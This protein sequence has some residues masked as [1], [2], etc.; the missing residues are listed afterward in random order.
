[1]I[2]HIY[3][4]IYIC[5]TSYIYIYIYIMYIYISYIYISYIYI[6]YIYIIYIYIIYIYISYIYIYICIACPKEKND[7]IENEIDDMDNMKTLTA[8]ND[9]YHLLP[10]VSH[11]TT[12]HVVGPNG[13]LFPCCNDLGACM[14]ACAGT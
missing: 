12:N 5:D 7:T 4:Y 14:M 9:N 2:Y 11:A 6:I 1:M 8:N 13:P 10:T 3:I